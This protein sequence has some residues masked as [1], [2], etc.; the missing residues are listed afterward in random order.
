MQEMSPADYA[1]HAGISRQAVAKA[2]DA[3]KIPFRQDGGRKLI[4]PAAADRARGV[5][6]ERVLAD[7]SPRQAD[8]PRAAG[9]TQAKTATEVYRAR[10]AELDY[11]ERLGKVRAV[12]DFTIATQRC[13]EIAI[14]A[15]ERISGRADEVAALCAKDGVL[16]ARTAL[17]TIGRDL[18]ASIADAFAKLAAGDLEGDDETQETAEQ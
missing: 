11:N 9:L 10:L 12:E 8:A 4:D 14:R 15:I 16:G 5:N 13:A 6:V 7:D 3:G 17:R 1:R 2:M 18:R